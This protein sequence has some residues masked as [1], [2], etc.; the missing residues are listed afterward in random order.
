MA[1]AAPVRGIE[2]TEGQRRVVGWG[3]GTL[4]V[5]GA[6]ASGKTTALVERAARLVEEGAQAEGILFFVGD[7]RLTLKLRDS[8]VRRLG[9]SVA[10]PTIRTFHGFAWGLL[11]RAFPIVTPDGVESEIGYELVGLE[12]EPVLLTAFDQRAFVRSMLA[13]EDPSDWPVNASMLGSPAFAGEV[14]DFLLRAQERLYEPG[15]VRAKAKELGRRDWLEIAGFYERYRI[16]LADPASFE[17]GRPRLDFAGVLLEARHLIVEHAGVLMDLRSVFPHILVDDFEEANRAERALLEALLP[18]DDDDRSA[19]VT[20]DPKGSV[21]AFRGADPAN[22][23]E[24]AARSEIE[25]DRAFRPDGPAQVRLYSHVTEEARGVVAD[26]RTAHSEGRPWGEMAVILRDY[27]QLVSP[28]RRE[29]RRFQVPFHIE[30]EALHLGQDPVIRPIINLFTI[31]LCRPGYEEL[32][33]ELLASDLGRMGS[34]ELAE[35]RRAARLCDLELHELCGGANVE[36]PGPIRAKVDALCSLVKGARRWAEELSP[37]DAFW[38]LWESSEAFAD[39]VAMEDSRKLDPYT[40]FADALARFAERR[41]RTSRMAD[42]LDTLESAEFAPESLRLAGAGEAVTITTAHAA[43]G[44]EFSFAVV[45]GASEG[46]WPDPSRRGVMLE[47]DLLAG[48][49]DHADRTRAALEEEERLFRA[50]ATRAKGVVFTGQSAGGSDVTAAEPSR[51]LE[52][53]AALPEENAEVPDLILTPREAEIRWRRVAS[54]ADLDPA[55]RLAAV[56]GLSNLP[57]LDPSRWWWG[58][59]WTQNDLPVMHG[60]LHSSYSRYSTYENC[61]L[62]YLLGQVLGLDPESTYQMAFGSLIHNLLEDLEKKKLEPDLETLV[63]EG[64]RRWRDEA[65]PAGAVTAY[66]RREMRRILE[67]YLRAEYGQHETIETEKP[68]ELDLD[69]WHIS[70][71]IDRIDRLENGIRLIDYKTS[72]SKKWPRE[73]KEDLQLA[74]YLLACVRND[75]LKQLGPPKAAELVYVR[76]EYRGRI[77]R[78]QQVPNDNM[79]ED[80]PTPWDEAVENRIKSLLEGIGTERFTPNVKADCMFCKFKTLCPLWAEGEELRVG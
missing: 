48:L 50:A 36:L 14:R 70:G 29:L 7:R 24:L 57:G 40:T 42:F 23:M 9:R 47:V 76:H 59:R 20:G 68:F 52:E 72:N 4:R 10:G 75:E 35:L 30:G 69:G 43:K 39:A 74:T 28:L 2:L 31:A 53:F 71:R 27:R 73:A 37:D 64:E 51:F 46:V 55:R 33:P 44:R 56:W 3:T 13:E 5:T 16:K 1:S 65:F 19:V 79:I 80:D 18:G 21:F 58:L 17:D 66:L 38:K 26:L 77:D 12:A 41:G 6:A 34:A 67:L 32:W 11:N 22:L 54:S 78:V 15:D 63:A 45:A 8:L 62:Q 61:G 25:L 49:K 60:R